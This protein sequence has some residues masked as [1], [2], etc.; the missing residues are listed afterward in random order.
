MSAGG[1]LLVNCSTKCPNP[2]LIS[3]ETFLLKK[4]VGNGLGWAAFQ[5]CNVTRDSKVLCSGFCNG[6]QMTGSSNITVYCECIRLEVD[7]P[8]AVVGSHSQWCGGVGPELAG[9]TRHLTQSLDLNMCVC[10][11]V[12]ERERQRETDRQTDRDASQPYARA[13][14]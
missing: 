12:C 1:S 8:Q 7:W 2:K 3:L 9:W 5:L 6:S 11:C 4:P 10:V 14:M 13:A